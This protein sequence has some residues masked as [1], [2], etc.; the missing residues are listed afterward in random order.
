M[1]DRETTPERSGEAGTTTVFR[2]LLALLDDPEIVSALTNSAEGLSIDRL[3][4]E[5]EQ[6]LLDA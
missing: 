6:R 3:R 4:R 1:A 2:V 5:T